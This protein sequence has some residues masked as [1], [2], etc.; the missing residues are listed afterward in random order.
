MKTKMKIFVLLAAQLLAPSSTNPAAT[1]TPSGSIVWK[2]V[3]HNDWTSATHITLNGRNYN[4]ESA[5]KSHSAQ[6]S[7][8]TTSPIFR[9]E[10][11]N[12]EL[13][14]DAMGGNDTERAELDGAPTLYPKGTEFWFA[15]QFLIEP[16]APQIATSGGYPGG[17]LAWGVVGQIHGNGSQAAVPWAL[18]IVGEVLSIHTQQGAQV[19]KT[20]WRSENKIVRGRVYD[21][22]VKIKITGDTKSTMTCWVDGVQVANSVGLTIGGPDAANYVKVGIYRGWQ[23]EGYPPLAV[24]IANIEH[25]TASLMSRVTTRAAWPPAK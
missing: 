12:N 8:N 15:Y 16:G 7:T 1:Q 11:R 4:P 18:S 20:H 24:Q 2:S 22:V 19:D 14:T 25:G 17:P 21:V 10:V 3:A 9:G 23:S 13:W 5:E 6:L